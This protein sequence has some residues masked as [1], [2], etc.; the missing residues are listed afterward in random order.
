MK[1]KKECGVISKF[2]AWTVRDG[3][4]AKVGKGR[5]STGDAVIQGKAVGTMWSPATLWGKTVRQSG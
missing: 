5:G 3:G 1:E 2:L 4:I